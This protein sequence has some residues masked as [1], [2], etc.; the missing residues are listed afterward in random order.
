MERNKELYE[1]FVHKTRFEPGKVIY[2]DGESIVRK[3][4]VPKYNK[5]N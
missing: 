4:Q 5:N 2:E 3:I 1:D